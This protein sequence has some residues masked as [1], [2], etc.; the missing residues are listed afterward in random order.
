MTLSLSNII[1][2]RTPCFFVSPHLDDAALS[3]ASLMRHLVKHHVPVTVINV[4]TQGHTGPQTLSAKKFVKASGY[5]TVD[6][7]YSARKGEDFNALTKIGVQVINLDYTDAP[8][9]K[10]SNPSKLA[11]FLETYIPEVTHIYPIHRF[12]ITTGR[13]SRWDQVLIGDLASRLKSLLP[14][15]A[16]LFCPQGVGGHVDHCLVRRAVESFTHPVLWLDQ[17]YA[18]K[19]SVNSQGF[20]FSTRPSFKRAV[21]K[22]YKTQ[23]GQLFPSGKI[24]LLE[25]QF[26][27]PHA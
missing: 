18:A 25:E 10:R 4:F 16:V 5:A 15:N 3:A 8:W 24:P 19:R 6:S 20:T 13:V 9:R 27:F 2:R 14:T 12:H 11:T 26:I 17:P 7:L 23:I 22:L 1:S 21:L